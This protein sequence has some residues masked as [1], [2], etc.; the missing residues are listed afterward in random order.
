MPIVRNLG[1][2]IFFLFL[3]GCAC[4]GHPCYSSVVVARGVNMVLRIATEQDVIFETEYWRIVLAKDQ[5][6][7]G[8]SVIYLKRPAGD[9]A[10]ITQEELNDWHFVLRTLEN[11]LTK[12]FGATVYN[13][14][15][16]T[17]NLFRWK[18][19]TPLVHWHM[20]PRYN[21]PVVFV[22]IEFHDDAFGS[23][24]E[25]GN[26]LIVSLDVR[27]RIIHEIQKNLQ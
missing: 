25:R 12:S 11:A 14:S 18:P 5:R 6:Y 22:G 4:I 7:L 20:R 15:Y 24:Y 23:H 17:N 26:A 16:L 13:W 19:Y 8:R 1:A 2:C 10:H 21:H 3:S 9:L 27:R